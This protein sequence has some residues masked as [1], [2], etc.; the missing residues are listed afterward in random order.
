ME[1][2]IRGCPIRLRILEI[3]R[4]DT[5]RQR[6]ALPRSEDSIIKECRV[7]SQ[8]KWLSITREDVVEVAESSEEEGPITAAA[9]VAKASNESN[10]FSFV[11]TKDCQAS[12]CRIQW[13]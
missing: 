3:K 12:R 1:E 11:G 10:I 7:L 4:W 9:D 8:Q 5:W 2:Q 13:K 6:V